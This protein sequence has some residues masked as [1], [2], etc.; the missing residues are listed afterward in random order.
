MNQDQYNKTEYLKQIQKMKVES[1]QQ[2]YVTINGI[3]ELINKGKILKEEGEWYINRWEDQ[4][5]K[6]LEWQKISL[7][8][9]TMTE[10]E[11]LKEF[12]KC[13][14]LPIEND[15]KYWTIQVKIL[16]AFFNEN[17]D[18]NYQTEELFNQDS[19]SESLLFNSIISENYFG[20]VKAIMDRFIHLPELLKN[21]KLSKVTDNEW[22]LHSSIP[23]KKNQTSNTAKDYQGGAGIIGLE[24]GFSASSEEEAKTIM[25]YYKKQMEEEGFNEY[26][27]IWSIATR[28]GYSFPLR[29]TEL[30]T[31]TADQNRQNYFGQSEKKRNGV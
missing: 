1:G 31:L 29:L 25:N 30:M 8:N 7:S 17:H 14:G 21:L 6:V 12:T 2:T 24:Y 18:I 26:L 11:R 3:R 15:Y 28:K 22:L 19:Q 20:V 16:A 27:A 5:R 13:F 9:Q 4:N 23:S 10:E